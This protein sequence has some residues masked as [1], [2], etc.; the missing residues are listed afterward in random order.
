M[1]EY[2]L[3]FHSMPQ[4]HFAHRFGTNRYDIHFPAEQ[5]KCIEIACILH[6]GCEIC[7]PDN[8]QQISVPE[9]SVICTLFER[10]RHHF[11]QGYHEHITVSCLIE[12][13]HAV[14]GGLILPH[15]LSFGKDE[16]P[17]LPL[18]EQLVIQHTAYNTSP[19]AT[20]MLWEIMG[21]LSI[22]HQL[23]QQKEQV[24]GQM[25]YVKKAQDFIAA[26]I[27]MPIRIADVADHLDISQGYLSH[28]F[29]DIV[30]QTV[31]EY[32]N[33]V[34]IRRVEELILRT[35]LDVRQA[36]AQVGLYDP[37]YVSRLF[38]KIKGYSISQLRKTV[39]HTPEKSD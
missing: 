12:Y 16:N 9:N 35:G 23:G 25:W 26:N 1:I 8:G 17:I 3:Y 37:N 14:N 2:Q 24:T 31:V 27:A 4:I 32:I 15:V 20:G 36:G 11:C 39:V 19:L 29:T 6:G 33:N 10:P 22:L 21:K 34:R 13:T 7:Y 5:G 18:L 30:G 38:R 28:L